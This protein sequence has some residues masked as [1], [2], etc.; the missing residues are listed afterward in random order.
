LW[1]VAF[2]QNAPFCEDVERTTECFT[3]V[4]DQ[5]T[6]R[7]NGSVRGLGIGAQLSFFVD[8]SQLLK[9]V[10]GTVLLAAGPDWVSVDKANVE[11][12]ASL[13]VSAPLPG[14]MVDL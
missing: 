11:L 8:Q 9:V 10:F 14:L 13:A 12:P 4:H 2:V 7:I 1:G 3:L 5:I 6:N